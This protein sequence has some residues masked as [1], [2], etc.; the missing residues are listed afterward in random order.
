MTEKQRFPFPSAAQDAEVAC[1][2]SG[3]AQTCSDAYRLA[4][5][6]TD[7]LLREELRPVRLQLELLKPE[8]VQADEGITS[9]VVVFG[10]ARTPE[11]QVAA[12]LLRQA[13]SAAQAAPA[14]VSAATARMGTNRNRQ[15]CSMQWP[16]WP[17]S[18][19]RLGCSHGYPGVAIVEHKAWAPSPPRQPRSNGGH[20][21]A[22]C[23]RE[24]T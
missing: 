10:S 8:L 17:G 16:P 14:S 15:S 11:P 1:L 22:G 23:A 6:D 20:T 5:T 4:Y 21:L 9:T 12:E 13:E 19:Q 7:F 24:L 2:V 18:R 3:T